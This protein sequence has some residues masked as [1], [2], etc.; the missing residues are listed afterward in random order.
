MFSS[1]EASQ[2]GLNI[3]F[4][5]KL[6]GKGSHDILNLLMKNQFVEKVIRSQ[7]CERKFQSVSIV[8][9]SCWVSGTTKR[10]RN[11]WYYVGFHLHR[12]IMSECNLYI[13]VCMSPA[14]FVCQFTCGQCSCHGGTWL[15]RKYPSLSRQPLQKVK[16]F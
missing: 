7:P 11:F 14:G 6:K 12:S 9:I 1:R 4:Y 2:N 8:L 13:Y 3:G 5:P 15:L 10:P 16:R